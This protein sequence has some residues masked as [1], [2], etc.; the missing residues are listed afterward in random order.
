MAEYMIRKASDWRA[1]NK[2]VHGAY[3]VKHSVRGTSWAIEIR[4]LE[5]LSHLGRVIVEPLEPVS[6]ITIYDAPVE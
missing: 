2:P 5:E 4:D 3:Q 1:K 6:L